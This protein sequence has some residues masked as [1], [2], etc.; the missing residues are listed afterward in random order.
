MAKEEPIIHIVVAGV[1][2]GY[3]N[4]EPDGRWLRDHH[5][6]QIKAVSPR[7]R[8]LQTTR[9]ELDENILPMVGAEVLLLEAGDDEWYRNEIPD[10]GFAKLVKSNLR[11]MQACSSGVS[12]ILGTGLL[13]ENVTL[14]NA[15]GVHADALGEST[16]AAVLFH[17]KQLQKRLDNQA[18]RT[19]EELHCD[20]LRGRTMTVLGI[21]HIGSAVAR[22]AGAFR[23]RLIGVRRNP[24]PTEHFE[25]VVGPDELHT[26]LAE[27]DYLVIA[28][29]LTD[30][31]HGMIGAP[32]FDAIKEGAYLIN[33][34]R[35]LV[36][37]QQPLLAALNSGKL[38]GAFLDAH[39]EEPL[40]NDHPFWDTS[41]ITVIPH[42]SHSSPY[43]GDNI[44]D[45]FTDNLRRYIAGEPLRNVIDRE[46]GY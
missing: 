24:Q 31:T 30:E 8:L 11:W 2:R 32:E 23:M 29:P 42:D 10:D 27:T 34:S 22:L 43:I 4:P 1:P 16:M 28:C 19:W 18:T 40:P 3:Q 45:L 41:G 26:V 6:E 37:Q 20:E 25:T 14:T 33:V 36:V 12:H 21:G 44:V 35:G 17:A 13:D 39:A 7:V 9:D 15:A 38:S 5:I 46:R